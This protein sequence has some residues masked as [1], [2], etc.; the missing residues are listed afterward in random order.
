[1]FID[2]IIGKQYPVAVIPLLEQAKRS[3]DV[4]V[5]DW[6]WYP[7][8]VGSNCQKF[9]NAMVAA[10]RRGVAIRVIT[11]TAFTVKV[12]AGLGINAKIWQQ[13][14]IMH[15]KMLLVDGECAVLGSHNF[16][17]NAFNLNQELSVVVRH[18]EFCKKVSDYFSSLWSL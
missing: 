2:S 7:D 14:K 6:R 10:A 12:L 13:G 8:Q 1:M 3:I 9:N 5:Y 17:M 11:N 18:E 15:T 16:T 4:V